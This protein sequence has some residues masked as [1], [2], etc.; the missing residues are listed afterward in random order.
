M[1]RGIG[2]DIIEIGSIQKA[3]EQSKRFVQ[4]VFTENE[5]SYRRNEEVAMPD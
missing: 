1:I 2:T 5:I 3:M 4:R